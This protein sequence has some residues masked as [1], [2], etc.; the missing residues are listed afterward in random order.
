MY[1]KMPITR[2]EVLNAEDKTKDVEKPVPVTR[3]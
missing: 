1:K 3:S 2:S